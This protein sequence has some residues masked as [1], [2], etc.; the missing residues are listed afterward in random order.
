[1]NM[2]IDL[3]KQKKMKQKNQKNQNDRTAN[4]SDSVIRFADFLS[5][6]DPVSESG[7]L[8]EVTAEGETDDFGIRS[9]CF[10]SSSVAGENINVD[11][12][13]ISISK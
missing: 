13:I 5:E 2:N 12:I 6:V 9:C 11:V 1:M 7:A 8:N 10:A 4:D 3:T